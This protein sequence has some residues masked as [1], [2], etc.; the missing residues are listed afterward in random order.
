[1]IVSAEGRLGAV[2]RTALGIH[3]D[4]S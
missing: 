3:S 4:C 1:L 2:A